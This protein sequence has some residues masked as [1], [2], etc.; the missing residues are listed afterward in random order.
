MLE[1][2][3]DIGWAGLEH[4]YGSAEDVPDMMRAAC[5]P[6]PEG[7]ERGFEDLASSLCHQ[8]S[9]YA[10]TVAAVPFLAELALHGP[11]GPLEPLWLLHGAADGHGPEYLECRRAVSEALPQLLGLARHADREVRR[12]VLWVIA[13]CEDRSLPLLP[14]LRARWD[15][16]QDDE[17][18][19][20]LLTALGLLE[21]TPT[22]REARSRELLTEV[23]GPRTRRAAV[24]D[25]LRTAPLPLP[26]DLVDAAADAY[27]AAPDDETHHPWPDGRYRRLEDRLLDDP[28]AA[29]RAARRGMPLAWEVTRA[30]RDREHEVLPL[31]TASVTG[32]DLCRI[33]RVGA[34]VPGVGTASWL[35]PFLVS[36][37][38]AE[39]VVATYT[40]VRLRVPDALGLVLRLMEELPDET[41]TLRTMP[42][43][44][45]QVVPAAV[46][47]FGEAA[48]PVAAR[49]AACLR[50][51]WV[52]VLR[53][54]P[55]LAADRVDELVRLLPAS[56]PVL[57]ALGPAAG[58]RAARA[59]LEGARR[60][61]IPSALAHAKVTGD[62]SAA[63]GLVRTALEEPSGEAV[64]AAGA[65]G[66]GAAALLPALEPYLRRSTR[67]NR[68]SAATAIWRITGRTDDT[69]PVL[70]RQIAASGA[71]HAPQLSALRTLTAMGTL[72]VEAR[73]AVEHI[74][75]SPRRVVHDLFCD[76]SPS[77]DV[78]ARAAARELL[79]A[80]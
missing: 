51:E 80:T 69:A 18:R 64:E 48:E 56:A 2:I 47:V 75:H 8:G 14:L 6:D 62:A 70:A 26:A 22:V 65:L 40:A 50:T 53:H 20:D 17:V 21:V 63:V 54:F 44:D 4:A 55:H 46:E 15:E 79:A 25:L 59:L 10:A 9:V 24:T 11:G 28:E 49:V 27:G 61:D 67:E 32:S 39:R 12:A 19:A 3:D 72:P 29:L 45:E 37:D 76:G 68:A 73:P 78:A 34:E 74:A 71:Y 1:G 60:G 57:G 30:W 58:P 35:V 33:A 66:P 36:P 13:A 7:R 77:G 41:A 43:S 52:G 16:E 5:S 42:L 23:V 31:L 38:P